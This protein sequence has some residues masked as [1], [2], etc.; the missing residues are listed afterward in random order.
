[1][2]QKN[3][4]LII[5]GPTATGKTHLAVKLARQFHGEIISVD[6]RQVYRGLDIGTGKDIEEYATGGATVPYHLID[7]VDPNEDYNLLRFRQDVPQI[8]SEIHARNHLPIVAGGTPLYIDSLISDYEMQ[9]GPPDDELRNSLNE[10]DNETLLQHLQEEF[11]EA[12]EDLKEGNNRKRM[13]RS[14]ERARATHNAEIPDIPPDTEWL[15]LGVYFHRKAVHKRIEERLDARL[16]SGMVEEVK[17]LHSNGVSWERLEFFGLEY[18]YIALHLQEKLT[19]QEMRDQLLIKIR[20]FGKRQDIWFRKMERAGHIIHWIPEGDM[21]Q[22]SEIV[23]LFLADKP[24]PEP[25]IKIAE[26]KYG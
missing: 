3:K 11:P 8:L 15:I 26:I 2:S 5:T 21:G 22:A 16:N 18:K 7:V 23:E 4:N 1:L 12:Y 17:N 25:E 6:S 19:F 20:Q 9:G 10:L 14:L 24:I 13:I